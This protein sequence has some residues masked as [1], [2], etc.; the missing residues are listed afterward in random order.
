MSEIWRRNRLYVFLRPYVDACTRNSYCCVKGKGAL[1]HDGAVIIAPNHTNTLMDALVILQ[2]RRD[3][4]VFA[5][6]ADI[7]RKPSIA[8]ILRFLKIVPMARSRDN[9]DEIAHN[10]EVL[11]EIDDT[12][13]HNV[14]FCIFS[15]GRHRPMHSLLPIRKGIAR[16]AIDS[17]SRRQTYIVPAGID[18]SDWFHYRG[19]VKLIYGEPINVNALVEENKGI[20]DRELYAL[21]QNE[22]YKRLSGLILFFPDDE[23]YEAAA[24]EW[25]DA[26]RRPVWARVLRIALAVLL[27]PLFVLSALLVLPMWAGAEYLCSKKIQDRA[28]HNTAR[29]GFKLLGTPLMLLIWGVVLALLIGVLPWWLC[30]ALWCWV[31]HSYSFFYDWLNLLRK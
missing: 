16:I 2:S 17:A 31:F 3:R 5:A 8:R 9:R 22:L 11:L 20:T 6:R 18:Y 15:E 12:L 30:L 23:N 29:Y 14:P 21:I 25:A 27:S 1:P 24:R 4:T 13:A 10:R 28:F 7:F 26:H 19:S